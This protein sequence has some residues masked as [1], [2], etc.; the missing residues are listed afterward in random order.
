MFQ[1]TALTQFLLETNNVTWF[2]ILYK[3]SPAKNLSQS[4]L[5]I[6]QRRIYLSSRI[7]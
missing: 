5:E 1:Y 3:F 6:L 7:N 4:I 2:K